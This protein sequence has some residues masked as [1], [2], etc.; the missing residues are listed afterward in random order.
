MTKNQIH[1][2]LEKALCNAYEASLTIRDNGYVSLFVTPNGATYRKFT[3]T[4]NASPRKP[5]HKSV[6]QFTSHRFGIFP[7]NDDDLIRI[8][9]DAFAND[10]EVLAKFHNVIKQF[11]DKH[12]GVITAFEMFYY[13]YAAVAN[14]MVAEKLQKFKDRVGKDFG[15]TI[16][17]LTD[18]IYEN[19][20]R[21]KFDG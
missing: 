2:K 15:K 14:Q 7:N 6:Y 21:T 1:N 20:E 16:D 4:K 5:E 9:D 12:T 11:T 17:K 10:K 19:Q 18:W 8:I 3:K 13:Q